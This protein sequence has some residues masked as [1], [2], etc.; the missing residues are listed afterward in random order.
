M[1]HSGTQSSGGL[2]SAGLLV[3]FKF[4]FQTEGFYD[5]IY[6]QLD[7]ATGYTDVTLHPK[8]CL[9]SLGKDVPGLSGPLIMQSF[10]EVR[11]GLC[12]LT[13]QVEGKGECVTNVQLEELRN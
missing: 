9:L 3:G 11:L 1:W 12:F 10:K 5:S 4:L 2:C 13:Q 7:S 6:F 8:P